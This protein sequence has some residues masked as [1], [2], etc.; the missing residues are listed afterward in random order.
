MQPLPSVS[1]LASHSTMGQ[2]CAPTIRVLLT[3]P[4]CPSC[5]SGSS[6]RCHWQASLPCCLLP[7]SPSSVPSPHHDRQHS[8]P[9]GLQSCPEQILQKTLRA[10]LSRSSPSFI[11]SFL[12][13]TDRNTHTHTHTHTHSDC[14]FLR[15]NLLAWPGWAGRPGLSSS[16][17]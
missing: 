1:F 12:P 6:L 3:H 11:L 9:H 8:A 13:G 15:E 2:R 5:Q 17:R 4:R 16:S 14:L 7:I 10:H